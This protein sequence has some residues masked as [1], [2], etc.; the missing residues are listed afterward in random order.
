MKLKEFMDSFVDI[1]EVNPFYKNNMATFAVYID[2]FNKKN[3]IDGDLSKYFDSEI[4]QYTVEI[5]LLPSLEIY[6]FY[7]TLKKED[8]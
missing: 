7:I 1:K 5:E 2:T 4:K 3:Y 8:N 6:H